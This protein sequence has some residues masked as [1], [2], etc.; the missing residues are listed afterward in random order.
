MWVERWEF[1]PSSWSL[2]VLVSSSVR[3]RSR[4]TFLALLLPTL[5]PPHATSCGEDIGERSW[6]TVVV[7]RCK[8]YHAFSVFLSCCYWWGQYPPPMGGVVGHSGGC[9]RMEHAPWISN[10]HLTLGSQMFPS[11]CHFCEEGERRNL[12]GQQG[13]LS[14]MESTS[15]INATSSL[16]YGYHCW[17]KPFSFKQ[18]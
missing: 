15:G 11:S 3:W 12:S 18:L 6:W 7:F 2:A 4:N 9:I 10:H 5:P 13:Y 16:D 1:K 17:Y 14:W 8:A